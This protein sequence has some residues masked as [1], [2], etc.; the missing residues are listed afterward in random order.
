MELLHGVQIIT[1]K[2]RRQIWQQI[3]LLLVNLR[4][5][6]AVH[7]VLQYFIVLCSML[8]GGC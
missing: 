1:G 8:R 4:I 6:S 7:D 2:I 5:T 3:K